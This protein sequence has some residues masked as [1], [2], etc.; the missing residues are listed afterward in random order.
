MT[1]FRLAPFLQAAALAL[2][3]A[4]PHG[5]SAQTPV[6]TQSIDPFGQEVTLA[7]KAIVYVKGSG[8]PDKAYDIIVDAFRKVETYLDRAGLKA[9]G[10]PM[11][12]YSSL[13]DTGFDFQAAIPL[14]A[15][16]AEQPGG[17][18]AVGMSPEIKVLKFV[19]RGS[20]DDINQT[21]EAIM[22]DLDDKGLE[23]KTPLIE[24]YVTDPVTTPDDNL[25]V[26][27]YMPVD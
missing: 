15:P 3:T 16:P 12:I 9:S 1:A 26:N 7:A 6:P 2:A 25:V 21:Y 17:E 22:N 4:W 24:E 5:A 27:I 20:F 19:H 23:A 11:M 14:A 13:D 18:I 10:P 8:T